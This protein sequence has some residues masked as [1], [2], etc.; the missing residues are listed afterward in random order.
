MEK[1]EPNPNIGLEPKTH[2]DVF[3]CV[4]VRWRRD[5]SQP[6]QQAEDEL[7]LVQILTVHRNFNSSFRLEKKLVIKF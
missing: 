6:W 5:H 4:A 1:S 7:Y 2:V 3:E